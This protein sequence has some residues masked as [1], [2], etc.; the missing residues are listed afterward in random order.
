MPI[1][2]PHLYSSLSISSP[3]H[4][5]RPPHLLNSQSLTSLEPLLLPLGLTPDIDSLPASCCSPLHSSNTFPKGHLC[6]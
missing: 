1:P 5:R 3:T 4:M 6:G 2:W